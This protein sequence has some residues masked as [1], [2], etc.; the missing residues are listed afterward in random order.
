MATK[1]GIER[2]TKFAGFLPANFVGAVPCD[3]NAT[4]FNAIFKNASA[5]LVALAFFCASVLPA[6][7]QPANGDQLVNLASLNYQGVSSSIDARA[8]VTFRTAGGG[9]VDEPVAP[10]DLLLECTVEENCTGGLVIENQPGQVLGN[11]T[12]VDENPL[13]EH[14]ISVVDDIRFEVVNNQLKLADG[15]FID[16]E[17]EPTLQVTL[18]VLDPEGFTLTKVVDIVVRDVNEE[19]FDLQSNNSF[20]VPGSSERR[21]GLLTASDV[22]A[23]ETQTFS[24]VGDDRFTIIDGNILGLAAGVVLEPDTT[25]PVTVL[26]TDK[27]GLTAR[28]LVSVT[29]NPPPPPPGGGAPT[30]AFMA[31]DATGNPVNVPE[32]TCAPPASF[33]PDVGAASSL[34]LSF[35]PGDVSGPQELSDVDAYAIGDPVIVNVADAAANIHPFELDRIEVQL[36]IPAT[37]DSELLTLVET[38]VNTG[39]FFGFVFTTSQQSVTNDCILT[40]ASRTQVDGTYTN[41]NGEQTV[42]TLAQISPVGI[43]FNDETGEPINGVI[44]ALI[45]DETGE[46]AVVSGDGPTYAPY[47]STVITGET[48]TDASGA[49]YENGPGEYRFPAIP[50]GRYR[51]VIFNDEGWN[52]SPKPDGEIQALGGASSL[53]RTSNGR[54]ILTDASRG[55]PFHITQGAVPRIDIPV[56]QMLP[57]APVEPSPSTIEFLQYSANPNFGTPVDVGQTTCVAGVNS[58]AAELRDVSVPVPGVVNLAPATVFKAGQPIFVRVTDLDQNFDPARRERITIELSVPASGDREFVRLMET[59]PDT[60]QFVGYIQSTEN[61]SNASS[62]MLGV[63]KDEMI[64]TRYSD[65]FDESDI[66]SALVLVDPFGRIFSTKD[67][68]LIDG[69]SVTLIDTSTGLPADV[70]G[71]GPNFAPYPSTVISGGQTTDDAG[72]LYD[73]PE[74]EYRFPFVEPGFYQL[75]FENIPAG[76]VFPSTTSNEDIQS[77]TGAPFQVVEG[78]RGE[79]FEVPVGPALNIDIPLD[80]PLAEVFVSKTTSRELAAIGDFIQWRLNIE[81]RIGGDVSGAE[82]IDILPKGFRFQEGSLRIN[83]ERVPDPQTAEDGRTMTFTLPTIS[84]VATTVSYVTEIT[85]AAEIGEARNL[86]TVQGDQIA[87]SNTSFASVMVRN[88]LFS[89][90]AFLVGRVVLNQCREDEPETE[91]AETASEGETEIPPEPLEGVPG[92]RIYL[93]D[94]SYVV[95][96]ENGSWHMEGIEPGTHIVQMDVDS[97]A[98]RYEASPCNSNSRFA[99][100]PYSQFVDLQGGTL[101]RADFEVQD[102]PAPESQIDL[103][104]T[105]KIDNEGIWV[106]VKATNNGDVQVSDA[107]VIYSVPGGWQIVLES[108]RV[109]RSKI[110]PTI[111]ALWPVVTPSSTWVSLTIC[112]PP[113]TE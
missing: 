48:I 61:E 80:E 37:G 11:L 111:E 79:E 96:D 86:A 100:S 19:P 52:F 106:Q 107:K 65:V 47:P 98:E 58:Q 101:W 74:G 3:S 8:N 13:D 56:V 34:R 77:L 4:I 57:P 49:V 78:S 66:S 54:F 44:L 35:G 41:G 110:A 81:N 1:Y 43:L 102:K 99:G 53:T 21:I 33:I 62:C 67:G 42:S 7:A 23:N 31:P 112:Q 104:Q 24:V 10:T 63:V 109:P 95:T 50:E 72:L 92:V 89:E 12:V 91:V 38:D 94:G 113:G 88:D 71:D 51:L 39:V 70:F 14:T 75:R 68:R 45:N 40:V 9:E 29:T 73:F 105:L 82:V 36:D 108:S 69:V 97:L 46:P 103:E 2:T 6:H 28:T 22:D 30:I 55:L 20:V 84:G 17:A 85:A 83:G 26:V 18:E 76:L 16:F 15:E 90:K 93:E 60:G 59:G 87:S 32:A 5:T 64:Q 25:I 27:G